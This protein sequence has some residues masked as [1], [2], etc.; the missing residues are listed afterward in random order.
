MEVNFG[1]MVQLQ[2]SFPEVD[3]ETL[4]SALLVC[5]NNV[6]LAIEF[7]QKHGNSMSKQAIEATKPRENKANQQTMIQ[8]SGILR[9]QK[10]FPSEAKRS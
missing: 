2:I 5:N 4:E 6:P 10:F 3:D 1:A 8:S 7:L 9:L